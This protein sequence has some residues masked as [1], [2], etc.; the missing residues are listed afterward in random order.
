MDT[1][2]SEKGQLSSRDALDAA[3]CPGW[4]PIAQRV[5]DGSMAKPPA[6]QYLYQ[7]VQMRD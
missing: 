4:S 6:P 2:S 3:P 5:S 1:A 7:D